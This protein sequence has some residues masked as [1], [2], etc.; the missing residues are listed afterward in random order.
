MLR[1][2]VE[3]GGPDGPPRVEGVTGLSEPKASGTPAR[4]RAAKGLSV[5]ARSAPRRRAYMPSSP[6]QSASKAGWTEAVR[7]SSAKAATVSGV[8]ISA[9]SI[10]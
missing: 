6:P 5:R 8:S 1:G 10:R 9:C 7:P 3:G 4:S 2:A